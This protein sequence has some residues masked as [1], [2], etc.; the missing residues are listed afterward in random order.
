MLLVD[1]DG[2]KVAEVPL[3]A[4][5]AQVAAQFNAAASL[6]KPFAKIITKDALGVSQTLF[7][8]AQTITVRAEIWKTDM[9]G[10]LV[11]FAGTYP[12]PFFDSNG[13]EHYLKMVFANGVAEVVVAAGK[14]APS[15]YRA[16]KASSRLANVIEHE[17][18]VALNGA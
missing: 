14:L 15:K 8:T 17:I 13:R 16:T 10:I 2:E 5:A 11:A 3:N 7:T 6:A 9:S 4:T 12:V 18:I 1:I